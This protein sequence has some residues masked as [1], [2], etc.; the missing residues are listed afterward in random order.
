[1]T[2]RL[3]VVTPPLPLRRTSVSLWTLCGPLSPIHLVPCHVVARSWCEVKFRLFRCIT[4]SGPAALLGSNLYCNPLSFL[5]LIIGDRVVFRN[6]KIC[7]SLDTVIWLMSR[8]ENSKRCGG[9]RH[10]LHTWDSALWPLFKGIVEWDPEFIDLQV[11]DMLI[12][13]SLRVLGYVIR[14]QI[15]TSIPVAHLRDTAG[16]QVH[17]VDIRLFFVSASA[18]GTIP[19]LLSTTPT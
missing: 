17:V 8:C 16:T 11:Q 15:N 9:K 3:S 14:V 7:G 6:W 5:V 18:R 10:T 2:I 13:I 4:A 1:M 12:T 19:V